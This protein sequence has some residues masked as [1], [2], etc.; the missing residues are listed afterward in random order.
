MDH[1][2]T[3]LDSQ[4]TTDSSLF[5]NYYHSPSL[6]MNQFTVRTGFFQL[7]TELNARLP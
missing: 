3:E 7:R 4:Q 2:Q 1:E 6:M 5:I